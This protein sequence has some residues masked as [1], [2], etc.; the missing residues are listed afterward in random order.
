M[1]LLALNA[2]ST[3]IKLALYERDLHQ[4]WSAS[5]SGLASPN[6]RL[7]TREPGGDANTRE[8]GP[9]H[10]RS[11]TD[12]LLGALAERWPTLRI[13]AVGHRV[14]HGGD[15]PADGVTIDAPTL[16]RI[17][18]WSTLAPLH[19]HLNIAAINAARQAFPGA[20]QIACF[21]TGFHRALPEHASLIAVPARLRSLGVRRYGFHGLSYES[22]LQQLA[23][24]G[25]PVLCERVI[26]A[27]LGGGSSLCAIAQGRSVET[28]MG[29]TPLS[30]VPMTTRCGDLDPGAL[31]FLLQSGE[32]DVRQ[33]QAALYEE[34]GLKALTGTSGDMKLLLG[35]AAHS[36]EARK[37]VDYFCYQVRRHMG[38]LAAAMEGVDRIV[39][40]GGIGANAASIR[41]SVCGGLR[42]LGVELN[43]E[44]NLA[45]ASSVHTPH[46]GIKVNVLQTDEESVLA[47]RVAAY[48]DGS[49]SKK[50]K[51]GRPAAPRGRPS[52]P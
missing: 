28:S 44:A 30:G 36:P 3:S 35:I 29:V 5:V 43:A 46:S 37:A 41:Q 18:H 20:R 33:L 8:L 10:F 40:T 16:A 14:V 48:L 26:A 32:M 50:K 38:A 15:L 42:F 34:S 6:A 2:G 1:T 19:Q 22:V 47:R 52:F 25:E 24:G 7:L 27:H 51:G 9:L 4:L 13:E 31:L 39:F 12:L 45:N 23:A 11:A 49:S 21:D 17:T